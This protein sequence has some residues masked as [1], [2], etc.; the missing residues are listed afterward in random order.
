M[1]AD[2]LA[3]RLRLVFGLLTEI[4]QFANG[5]YLFRQPLTDPQQ[6]RREMDI[7]YLGLAVAFAVS[8]DGTSAAAGAPAAGGWEWRWDPALAPS[9]RT[10]VAIYRKE[11]PASFVVLPLELNPE[12]AGGQP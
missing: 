10:A 6:V 9:V 1:T 8:A 3:D 11:Q 7:L 5:V 12:P 2:T 4:D